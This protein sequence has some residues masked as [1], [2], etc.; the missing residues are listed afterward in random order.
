MYPSRSRRP[1]IS[2]TVGGDSCIARAT[3][4]PVI[5]SPASCSQ[6]R[7]CRYSS[8]A[9]VA[10]VWASSPL[11][12]RML[13]DAP[14]RRLSAVQ[15]RERALPRRLVLAPAAQLRPVTDAPRGDV[16]EIDL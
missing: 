7:L 15:L 13:D 8:S 12:P 16:V 2:W 9:T 6:N 5:G 3:F 14:R 10:V 1:I 4:A 11:T